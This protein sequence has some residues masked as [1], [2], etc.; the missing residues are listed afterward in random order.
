M[1][2]LN[3]KEKF[4]SQATYAKIIPPANSGYAAI[5]PIFHERVLNSLK[6]QFF[7]VLFQRI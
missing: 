7:R 4:V 3:L 1:L 6:Q 2:N 5:V